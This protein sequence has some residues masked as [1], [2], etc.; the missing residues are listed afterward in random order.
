M[1]GPLP[2]LRGKGRGWGLDLTRER[3]PLR[4]PPAV[5]LI[6]GLMRTCALSL[7]AVLS[8]TIGCRA[9]TEAVV[10]ISTDGQCASV[11]GTGVT[12]GLLGEIEKAPYGATTQACENGDIGS[13][14][15]LPPDGDKNA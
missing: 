9:P 5:V 6:W 7:L 14:V 10:E 4:Q 8:T 15:L 3:R 12:A 2:P 13:I 11:A 1:A